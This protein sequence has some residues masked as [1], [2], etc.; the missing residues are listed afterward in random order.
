[1]LIARIENA[2]R[3]VGKSQGY[4]GLPIRDEV[5]IDPTTDEKTPVMVTAWEPSI[6]EIEAL[7]QGAKIHLTLYGYM[8]PPVRIDV[9]PIP[10]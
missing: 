3:V 9:G 8:H 1:M 5:V 10:E 7:R 6:E 4:L 2:T